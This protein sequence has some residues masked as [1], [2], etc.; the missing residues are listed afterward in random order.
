MKHSW[1]AIEYKFGGLGFVSKLG[2]QFV[3][4]SSTDKCLRFHDQL[5]DKGFERIHHIS[6]SICYGDLDINIII[7]YVMV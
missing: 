2:P 3:N 5:Y 1:Q 7:N 6:P 4:V